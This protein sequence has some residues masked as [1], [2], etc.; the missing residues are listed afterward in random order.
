MRVV[1]P[2]ANAW[3][4]TLLHDRPHVEARATAGAC[5]S[6]DAQGAGAKIAGQPIDFLA[7]V[8]VTQS[9]RSVISFTIPTGGTLAFAGRRRVRN[10]AGRFQVKSQPRMVHGDAR[11]ISQ[12]SSG[13]K[14]GGRQL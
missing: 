4:L 13:D 3:H 10:R 5:D 11:G 7:R 6:R 12:I 9:D 14:R 8:P 1:R 2:E